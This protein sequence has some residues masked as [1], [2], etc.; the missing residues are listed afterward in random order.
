VAESPRKE[1]AEAAEDRDGGLHMV[2]TGQI[3][4]GCLREEEVRRR[5]EEEEEEEKEEK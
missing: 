4:D 2:D 3:M 1:G 5:R